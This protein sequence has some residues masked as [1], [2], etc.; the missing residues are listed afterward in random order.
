ML[1]KKFH[2]YTTHYTT[3][4]HAGSTNKINC[5]LVQRV[6]AKKKYLEKMHCAVTGTAHSVYVLNNP[7]KN[8][9]KK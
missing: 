6:A 4:A 1:E 9:L 5:R 7:P 8:S 3:Q 2:G